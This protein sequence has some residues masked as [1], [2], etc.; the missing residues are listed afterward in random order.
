[1]SEQE[2]LIAI[3]E[4]SIALIAFTNIV[5]ALRQMGGGCL[6]EF[7]VLVVRLFS[8]CGFCTIFFSLLPIL[9]SYFGTNDAWIWRISN[10]LLA[11]S[12]FSINSWYFHHR[13]RIAPG[14]PL[15][16]ANYVTTAILYSSLLLLTLG[17]FGVLFNGSVAPFAFT[18]VGLLV[19]SAVAF[20]NTLSDF[21]ISPGPNV[22]E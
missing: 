3:A 6:S 18:L 2:F 21:L 16:L 10:P 17:T 1:M 12:I 8:V 4:L 9:L 5:V 13:R 20:L 19:A 22:P 11:I 7:Q 15:K 14:R